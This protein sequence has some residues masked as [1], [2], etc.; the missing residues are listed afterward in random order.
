MAWHLERK[1]LSSVF[2]LEGEN[3]WD[4]GEPVCDISVCPS[5]LTGCPG[6]EPLHEVGPSW[7]SEKG[8]A[9]NILHRSAQQCSKISE[10]SLSQLA[11]VFLSGSSTSEASYYSLLWKQKANKRKKIK[12]VDQERSIFEDI[13]RH[14]NG[15]AKFAP[16]RRPENYFLDASGSA[17]FPM[18]RGHGDFNSRAGTPG[19][20]NPRGCIRW[21]YQV[22]DAGYDGKRWKT[23]NKWPWIALRC[24]K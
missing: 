17:S 14:I 18:A 20:P 24:I 21:M 2:Y 5:Q 7:G 4:P 11:A 15:F 22:W 10:E 6:D 8:W 3:H 23:V 16:F 12:K 9:R 19:R 13:R 1:P